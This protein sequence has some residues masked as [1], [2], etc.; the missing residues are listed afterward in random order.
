MNE[1]EEIEEVE[2]EDPFDRTLFPEPVLDND[3]NIYLENIKLIKDTNIVEN[4]FLENK[5]FKY[6]DE[7]SSNNNNNNNNNTNNLGIK[8]LSNKR[9][10]FLNVDIKIRKKS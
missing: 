7:C 6:D 5:K 2:E 10:Y 9:N 4:M 8:Q 3:D 1:N